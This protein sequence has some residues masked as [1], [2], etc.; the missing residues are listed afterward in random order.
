MWF[1]IEDKLKFGKVVQ[2]K[3]SKTIIM[4]NYNIGKSTLTTFVERMLI[5]RNLSQELGVSPSV[6]KR[7]KVKKSC[8]FDKLYEALYNW[9][10][11]RKYV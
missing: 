7:A 2:Q 3:V 5:F 11:Q 10:K 6:E 9:P 4:S 8:S 1:T